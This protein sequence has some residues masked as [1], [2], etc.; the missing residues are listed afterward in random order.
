MS[1]RPVRMRSWW[2]FKV[3]GVGE[4]R[5]QELVALGPESLAVFGQL[6]AGQPLGAEA[7]RS[8]NVRLDLGGEGGVL[9]LGDCD[10]R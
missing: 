9:G 4:V 3:S 6:G 2:C 7:R 10:V 8:P 5:G 1:A